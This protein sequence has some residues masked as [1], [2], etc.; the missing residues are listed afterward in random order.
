ME[1]K[2][3]LSPEQVIKNFIS[4][5]EKIDHNELFDFFLTGL[6]SLFNENQISIILNNILS[7]ADTNKDKSYSLIKLIIEN[8]DI[9]DK[10]DISLKE[11]NTETLQ[12]E[13]LINFIKSRLYNQDYNNV[14]KTILIDK[15]QFGTLR[16]NAL[17]L[18]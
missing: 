15:N 7:I 1:T 13:I 14:L 18:Y 2:I 16:R 6:S 5:I 9:K 11:I 3:S 17:N 10:V 12:Q 8:E 4:Q